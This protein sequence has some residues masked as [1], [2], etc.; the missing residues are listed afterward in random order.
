MF[1]S[2]RKARSKRFTD[3][4]ND[5]MEL[6]VL[7]TKANSAVIA[8]LSPVFFLLHLIFSLN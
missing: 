5:F 4:R 7:K 3:V 2:E 8:L 6:F 1:S